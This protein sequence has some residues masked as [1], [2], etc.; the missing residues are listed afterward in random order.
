LRGTQYDG[1]R[2]GARNLT[3][4]C[5]TPVGHRPRVVAPGARAMTRSAPPMTSE[6]WRA[7]DQIL[8]G[9]LIYTGDRRNEFV[10]RSCGN[11]TALRG[12]VSSL[13]AAHDGTPVDFLER[14]AI[15][16]HGLGSVRA[17]ARAAPTISDAARARPERRVSARFALYTTAAAL[18]LGTVAGGN[19]AH[20]AQ[21]L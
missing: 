9:A 21:T 12:E 10:A 4:D 11:D 19:L 13:L 14:P 3:C 2:R 1:G 15:E 17:R 6:R 20:L 18:G 8:Q 7:I 5:R 16:E